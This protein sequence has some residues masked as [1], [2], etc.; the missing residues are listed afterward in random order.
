[1][2]GAK[3]RNNVTQRFANLIFVVSFLCL[4]NPSE[5]DLSGSS[6]LVEEQATQI[7]EKAISL[8]QQHQ[9]AAA[10]EAFSAS[11]Q[12]FEELAKGEPLT[13]RTLDLM[14]NMFLGNEQFD[15]AADCYQQ[16]CRVRQELSAKDPSDASRI[17]DLATSFANLG[18]VD[19]LEK[20]M[21]RPSN[22]TNKL[23]N[24]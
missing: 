18:R 9:F 2:L 8:A 19:F 10:T 3:R 14:G 17:H 23:L 1:M 5:A 4:A 12:L 15:R 6:G 16:S 22:S 7:R 13:S 11:R 20:N 21:T 24:P